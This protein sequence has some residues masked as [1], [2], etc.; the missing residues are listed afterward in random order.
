M[1]AHRRPRR[2]SPLTTAV[3]ISLPLAV[4]GSL[5]ATPALAKDAP[6]FT[7]TTVA[8]SATAAPPSDKS[9]NSF[10]QPSV[11][12]SG[13]VVFRARTKGPEPFR[14]VFTRN[15]VVAGAAVVPVATVKTDV[16]Q[17]NNTGRPVQRVPVVPADQQ[18]RVR[19]RHPRAVVTGLG[20]HP[21]RRH[22]DA[23]R[24][25][26]GVRH[27]RRDAHDR[28]QPARRGSGIRG[29]RGPRRRRGDPVRPV[30]GCAR[31]RRR[32]DR[33]QGQLHRGRRREDRRLLPGLERSE[34]QGPAD[35][36]HRHPDPQPASQVQAH[37]RLDRAAERRS[38]PDGLPGPGRREQ[39]DRWWHLPGQHQR[40][41]QAAHARRHR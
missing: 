24:Y 5:L 23:D 16:P 12:T 1:H 37:L 2:R 14:G 13:L 39:P 27:G 40:Q 35:R 34:E 25:Q 11:N 20:V 22:R 18:E 15:A 36:Q 38:R 33:L 3:V 7:W 29:L 26:R 28:G 8:N 4:A 32:H 31:D 21:R 19:R 6:R 41:G 17:P 9:F 30:P 10:N